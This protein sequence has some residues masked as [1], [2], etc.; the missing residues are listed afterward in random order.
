M[1]ALYVIYKLRNAVKVDLTATTFTFVCRQ[2]KVER[3]K[4]THDGSSCDYLKSF[5]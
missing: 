1:K 3:L 4:T 5:G 2:S